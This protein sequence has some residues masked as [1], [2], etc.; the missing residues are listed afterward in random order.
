MPVERKPKTYKTI[1]LRHFGYDEPGAY[2][3]TLVTHDRR[4][5]F[6][7]IV[8]GT[9]KLNSVG[10]IVADEW[11]R[12]AELRPNIDLDSF[13][14]MPNH[15]HGLVVIRE[16]EK[17]ARSAA[18]RQVTLPRLKNER[19]PAS[20]SSII[21][22]FKAAVTRRARE[23]LRNPA[24]QVWQPRFNDH[25][26]REERDLEQIRYYIVNNPLQWH[27]DRH[28]PDHKPKESS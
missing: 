24:F 10:E 2:S 27:L 9:M 23:Q 20:I 7:E 15:I 6:G 8:N 12:T 11:G 25:V 19:S 1:R 22:G 17:S 5:I 26:I 21:A 13:I 18:L 28:N 4:C 14:I 3:L 16:S